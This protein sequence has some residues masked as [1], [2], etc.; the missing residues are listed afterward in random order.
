[1]PQLDNPSS[2]FPH[3][4]DALRIYLRIVERAQGDLAQLLAK[5]RGIE[6]ESTIIRKHLNAAGYKYLARSKKPK[7][8]AEEK[9]QRLD[10]A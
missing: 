4:S 2:A 8:S 3:L 5:D 6:V 9:R 7:Y 10:F 1:M